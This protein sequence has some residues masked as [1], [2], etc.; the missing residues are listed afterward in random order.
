MR[1]KMASGSKL[2]DDQGTVLAG[3]GDELDVEPKL[4][5]ALIAGGSAEEVKDAPSPKS[6][7]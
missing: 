3:P 4:G 7:K 2:A 5:K 6:R 1:I